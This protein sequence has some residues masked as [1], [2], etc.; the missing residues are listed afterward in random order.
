MTIVKDTIANFIGGV[1]Q[2]PDK[3]M[4]PNQC[5]KQVNLLPSPT[6]GLIKRPPT[7]HIAR[8]L[9][10][11]DK[12]YLNHTII[13]EDEKY[14]VFFTG[15]D[16]RVFKLSGEEV[17]VFIEDKDSILDY[18]KTQQP[19]KDLDATT[20]ADYTFILNK[21]KT[22]E[23][24]NE[25]SE[26]K[27]SHSALVFVK[28]GD[29]IT[30]YQVKINDVTA[31][32]TTSPSDA[33]TTKTN[34]IA[35]AL[36]NDLK[37]KLSAND[38]DLTLKN[39]C[40]LIKNK[41][42][43]DFNIQ[44]TDSNAD[45]N[46]YSFYKETEG[47]E[48]LP[49]VAPNGFII[50]IVGEDINIEDDYYLKFVTADGS[51]FGTGSWQECCQ[52]AMKY[53][54]NPVTMPHTLIRQADGT[55]LFTTIDWAVRGAGDEDSAPTPSFIG[56]SI[57]EI[58]TH[59]GRLGFLSVDKSH[60]SDTQD[61]FSF[62]KKTTLTE[63]DTDPIE[64]LSNSKMVLLKH[65]LP[66][67][68]DFLLFSET[69][70]FSI[71][72][73]DIFSNRTVAI[74][75]VMEYA[76][77]KDCKPINVG[78]NAFCVFENGDY[79]RVNEIYTSYNTKL[80]ARDITEHIPSYLPKGMYKMI[81][82]DANN[83]A[84][85]LSQAEASSMYIYN[86]YFNDDEK[87]QSA[88]GKWDFNGNIIN[89][90]FDQN[91]LFLTV[92]YDD[93]I[94]LE[95]I[96]FS[97]RKKEDGLNFQFYLDRKSYLNGEYDSENDKTI[98]ELPYIPKENFE[99]VNRAGFL[100]DNYRITGN[101]IEVNGIQNTLVIGQRYNSIWVSPK[102]YLRQQTSNNS[103]KVKEGLLMLKDIKLS[104]ANTGYFKVT[105][106]PKY[107]THITSEFEYTGK[108]IG[109]DSSSLER[110][111][112]SNGTFP[113]PIISLN[114]DVEI[115]ITNDSYLPSCFLSMEWIGDFVSRGE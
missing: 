39:S 41:K 12:H 63:L 46:M 26:N 113:I 90:D 17:E 44:T 87:V 115:E 38:W 42:E 21:K 94:Y 1:S 77:S 52:P 24:S 74:D 104:Y 23:L 8:L 71:K 47:M 3:I 4:F 96:N 25:L 95:K 97:P 79:S 93:G 91:Y 58:F 59:K 7:E 43:Q 29:Y 72:G 65:S 78:D 70:E 50:K 5:K 68:E 75:L 27:H 60:Y 18:V 76:C 80:S 61:I 45:R 66:L 28:Q 86:Y 81:C 103:M 9:D 19:L 14:T 40:I 22:I 69:A 64:V 112:I 15:N 89:A 114:E 111:P 102:I 51:D 2:Q 73:G 92:Q 98:F 85:F 6:D 53:K 88:W 31:V 106:T 100:I 49:T 20:I 109:M 84:C 99:V 30:D 107:N 105:V 101:T 37:S 10:K 82:S 108:I 34:G 13:K 55:F 54:I 16:I 67:N 36:Y 62:F 83:I 35:S 56:N 57:Q 110:I 32:Y 11:S 48:Q 33:G